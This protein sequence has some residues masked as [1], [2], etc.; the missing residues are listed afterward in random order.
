MPIR[1]LKKYAVLEGC[2]AVEDAEALSAWLAEPGGRAVD[3]TPCEHV[4]ASVLQVLLARRPRVRRPP[5][6]RWLVAALEAGGVAKA[7]G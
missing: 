7:V 4:H 3:L 6:D 1:Y 2:V 5:Q